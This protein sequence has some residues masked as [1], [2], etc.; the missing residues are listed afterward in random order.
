MARRLVVP[1]RQRIE[2]RQPEHQRP[3]DQRQGP[4]QRRQWQ[5]PLRG[6]AP[7]QRIGDQIRHQK[8]CAPGDKGGFGKGD[9]GDGTA[10]AESI[11]Y[12][13]GDDQN[14]AVLDQREGKQP[15]FSLHA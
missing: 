6:R 14:E 10:G 8:H 3:Y 7:V 11:Q 2:Q 1:G 15:G 9:P 4:Q 12:E 13:D 5:Q